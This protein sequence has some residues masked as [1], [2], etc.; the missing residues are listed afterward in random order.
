MKVIYFDTCVYSKLAEAYSDFVPE[1]EQLLHNGRFRIVGSLINFSEAMYTSKKESRKKILGCLKNFSY[2]RAWTSN[3]EIVVRDLKSFITDKRE[4]RSI[5]TEHN[6]V[7]LLDRAIAGDLLEEQ[8]LRFCG[9][10]AKRTKIEFERFE[11]RQKEALR[12]SWNNYRSLARP[13]FFE[14]CFR[15]IGFLKEILSRC[16]GVSNAETLASIFPMPRMHRIRC[17]LKYCFSLIYEH[18]VSADEER[19]KPD[20]GD[21]YDMF[22]AIYAGSCDIFVTADR[23]FSKILAGFSEPHLEVMFFDDFRQ[24]V[25]QENHSLIVTQ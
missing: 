11:K 15:E 5:W 4:A 7:G 21:A 20:D 24:F 18:L 10:D 3:H 8:V 19:C 2:S 1:L 13:E 22:H 6:W 9:D 16:Y 17:L 12:G 23:A 25:E 14:G